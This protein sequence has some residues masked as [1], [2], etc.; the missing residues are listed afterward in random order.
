MNFFE[1]FVK[2]Q[3]CMAVLAMT[4]EQL[5]GDPVAQATL[6]Q[7]RDWINDSPEDPIWVGVRLRVELL[8]PDV[9]WRT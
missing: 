8:L 7:I 4:P 3:Q 1:Q 6:L 5:D 2:Y 9:E